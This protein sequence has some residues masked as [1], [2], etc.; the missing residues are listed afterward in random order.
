MTNETNSKRFPIKH[1]G[2]LGAD[3]PTGTLYASLPMELARDRELT[4]AARSV[5]LYVWSH[6]EKWKTSAVEIAEKLDMHRTT[7]S[8][9]LSNLQARGWLVRQPYGRT[10]LKQSHEVWHIQL[11]NTRFTPEEVERLSATVYLPDPEGVSEKPTPSEVPCRENRHPPV[12]KSD[13]HRAEKTDTKVVDSSSSG[14][15]RS[16]STLV[17][18]RLDEEIGSGLEP[19]PL[20]LTEEPK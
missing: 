19:D 12:E 17:V 14:F 10:G 11:S 9:A 20:R 7:V 5:A 15:T 4:A 6:T 8:K 18:H 13:T 1:Y 2:E 3:G 16:E